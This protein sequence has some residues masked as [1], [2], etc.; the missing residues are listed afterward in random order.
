MLLPSRDGLPTHCLNQKEEAVLE[1][2]QA[3]HAIQPDIWSMLLKYLAVEGGLGINPVLVLVPLAVYP[4]TL[5]VKEALPFAPEESHPFT[6]TLWVPP[7]M[8]T[9]TEMLLDDVFCRYTR[10]EST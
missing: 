9:G 7:L 8:L 2:A 1:L 4:P 6:T 5:T 10:L 3:E